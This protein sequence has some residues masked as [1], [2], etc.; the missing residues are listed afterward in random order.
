MYLPKDNV[1]IG[2]YNF[3]KDFAI[4]LWYNPKTS[5]NDTFQGIFI[6]VNVVALYNGTA[7]VNNLQFVI[8][9]NGTTVRINIGTTKLTANAWYHL[10]ITKNGTN[11]K[12]FINGTV[13]NDSTLE[14]DTVDTNNN[15]LYLGFSNSN[16]NNDI[17]TDDFQIFN[18]AL[19]AEE[20]FALYLNRANTPKYYNLN[21]YELENT[22]N[23]LFG[24]PRG[25]AYT[26]NNL[27]KQ[28]IGKLNLY[29]GSI[30]FGS[31][32]SGGNMYLMI[33]GITSLNNVYVFSEWKIK[34]TSTGKIGIFSNTSLW[35]NIDNSSQYLQ[36]ADCAGK[37][38]EFILITMPI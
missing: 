17:Q 31:D 26:L 4:S 23:V 37:T 27:N 1:N 6:K 18:R 14:T 34:D 8:V 21:N 32:A 9:Q 33:D 28:S 16:Y 10:V 36:S 15:N 29:F 19:S 5:N 2:N 35:L 11:L 3:Q 25:G 12:I 20:V 7:T 38:M 13:A 30:T 22:N 24:C